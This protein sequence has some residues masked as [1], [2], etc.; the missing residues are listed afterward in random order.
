[1]LWETENLSLSSAEGLLGGCQRFLLMHR[2]NKIAFICCLFKNV[3][4]SCKQTL[5]LESIRELHENVVILL[6]IMH[7]H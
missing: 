4:D 2:Q 1:M 6:E 3:K 7:H 5:S